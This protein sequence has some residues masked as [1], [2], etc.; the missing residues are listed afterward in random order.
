MT[1]DP[2]G[3]AR[4][5]SDADGIWAQPSLRHLL[6]TPVGQPEVVQPDS[7]DKQA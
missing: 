2:G 3:Q 6:Q 4:N 7:R 1:R 5:K